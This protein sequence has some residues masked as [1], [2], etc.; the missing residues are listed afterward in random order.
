MGPR[1]NVDALISQLTAEPERRL[2][3]VEGESDR[4]AIKILAKRQNVE[5]DVYQVNDFNINLIDEFS[6]YGGNKGRI[7]TVAQFIESSLD[8]FDRVI[9]LI[10]QDLDDIMGW[11]VTSP[12]ILYT[13]KTSLFCHVV[14]EHIIDDLFK[15]FY[16]REITSEEI[17]Q[18]LELAIW[19]L[20]LRCALWMQ[21]SFPSS[22]SIKRYVTKDFGLNQSGYLTAISTKNGVDPQDTLRLLESVENSIHFDYHFFVEFLFQA[23]KKQ[24]ILDGT[25]SVDEMYR[26]FFQAYVAN[27]HGC[28][29][30]KTILA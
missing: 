20:N 22:I 24:G 28:E 12:L 7:L 26:S 27:A 19:Y 30:A 1:R 17:R 14:T 16:R 18:S 29:T 11:K 6:R 9:G 5:I 25:C 23:S 21:I 8:K 3:I 10:D 15:V 2:L 4:D 13:H